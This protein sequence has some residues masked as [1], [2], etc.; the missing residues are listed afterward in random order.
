MPD[1]EN[2]GFVE[3]V[4]PLR[5]A[6]I[7]EHGDPIS[8]DARALRVFFGQINTPLSSEL[9][10]QRAG[11]LIGARPASE[12]GLGGSSTRTLERLFLPRRRTD[13]A[14]RKRSG[15]SAESTVLPGPAI[16]FPFSGLDGTLAT[17]YAVVTGSTRG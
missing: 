1:R 11:I 7:R 2:R 12:G 16:P 9:I 6:G 5:P 15:R 4:R 17:L 3:N 14:S 13:S 10:A 8:S